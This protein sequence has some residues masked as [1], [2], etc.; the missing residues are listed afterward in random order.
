M[1]VRVFGS[2]MVLY[3]APQYRRGFSKL[4]RIRGLEQRLADWRMLLRHEAI[5]RRH[6]TEGTIPQH[7]YHL[8]SRLPQVLHTAYVHS[9]LR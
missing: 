1:R 9:R 5:D 7:A 6:N 3:F 8:A 2:A 4:K